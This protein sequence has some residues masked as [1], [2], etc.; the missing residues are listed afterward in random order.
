MNYEHCVKCGEKLR[1]ATRP[2]VA[3]LIWNKP[4]MIA[5]NNTYINSILHLLGFDNA[6]NHMERYPATNMNQIKEA[7]VDLVLLSSEPLSSDTYQSGP[8]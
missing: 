4:M 6:F 3:Y 8:E 1:G 7:A 2:R 5:G